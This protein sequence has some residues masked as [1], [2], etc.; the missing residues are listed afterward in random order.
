MPAK[1]SEKNLIRS[2]EANGFYSDYE[3][4]GYLHAALIRSPAKTGKVKSVTIEDLP[5]GYFFFT[6]EDIPA[7]KNI[8]YNNTISKI[9][10][11]DNISYEG[12]PLGILI[13]PDEQTVHSLLDSVNV[14][15]DVESLESALHNVM[16][17]NKEAAENFTDLV[18]KLNDMPSLD[19]VIDK[20]NIQ[21]KEDDNPI[22]Y[23]REVKYGKYENH[24]EEEIDKLLFEDDHFSTTDTWVQNFSTPKWQETEGAFCYLE[25]GNIHVYV[26]TK[27]TYF[28][29]KTIANTLNLKPEQVF[30]HKTRTAS[31]YPNGLWRTTQIATQ[32]AVASY[33]SKKPVKLVFTQK[34]QDVF[35]KPGVETEIT[36]KSAIDE[37]GT[38]TALNVHIDIDV[39]SSN[40]FAQ[41][42]TDRITLAAC[43]YYKPKN[44]YICATAHTS[45]NPP[46]TISPRVIDSQAFFAIENQIQKISYKTNIFPDEL[47]LINSVNAKTKGKK[48]FPYDIPTG[49]IEEAIQTTLQKSDFNRKYASFHME[50]MHRLDDSNN[51]FFAIPLRG[52]GI[53][54]GYIGSDFAGSSAFSY[55][56][57]I[58]VT[59]T[60]DDKVIIHSIKPSEVIQDI[61]KTTVSEI[62]QIPKQNIIINSDFEIKEI[63]ETP[64]ESISAIGIMTETIKKCCNEIQKKRF[65]QP[66]PL[67]SKKSISPFSGKKWNTD[68]FSGIPF[69]TT[70]FIATVVEVELDT[71]TYSEKIKGIWVTIDCGELFDEQA[72]IRSIK[73]EIQQELTALVKGKTVSCDSVNVNFIKSNN[74]AGQIGG[75]IHNTLPAAFSSA[76]SLALTTQL[77]ELPCTESQ[78]F[79]LIKSR[80][81]Q[82][83]PKEENNTTTEGAAE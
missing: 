63:P 50:A 7:E 1:K 13:G 55:N 28:T 37:N 62:L 60:T 45:Q 17:N 52:I 72:A 24:S 25:S 66:L 47:R 70:S 59:L 15:F 73:M 6:A 12:E 16:K 49:N 77:T 30:I 32:V 26:P 69:Y 2:L 44:L 83:T 9:F 57:K 19:T 8:S 27:W 67:T 3:K 65:H 75:L 18:D 71:Y 36:Y 5:E 46:T 38:L 64:E 11:Y 40:P 33:L 58:E 41:E 51:V 14:S 22:V 81:N 21:N 23:K 35:L 54:T 42:I 76:L 31:T 39:G 53:S 56:Q 61:W 20:K 74:K 29:Q 4:S 43:N 79:E 80:T 78:L 68:T 10:G 48:S 34:E 82:H